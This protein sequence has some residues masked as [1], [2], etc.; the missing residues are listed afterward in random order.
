MNT[1]TRIGLEHFSKSLFILGS[2]ASILGILFFTY[3]QTIEKDVITSQLGRIIQQIS[4]QIKL[5]FQLTNPAFI[6]NLT[7]IIH[8]TE[9]TSSTDSSISLNNSRITKYAIYILLGLFFTCLFLSFFIYFLFIKKSN[10][11]S[12]LYFS[13]SASPSNYLNII[14]KPS[15]ILLFVVVI[16]E[17]SFFTLISKNYRPIDQN[18]IKEYVVDNLLKFTK[19]CT[20]SGLNLDTTTLYYSPL[21]SHFFSTPKY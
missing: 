12:P 13:S 19:N 6:S 21:S 9:P 5:M 18:L 3:G 16:V 17:I 2:Y 11:L 4:D 7:K 8:N 20:I 10:K 1:N 14:I 15:L